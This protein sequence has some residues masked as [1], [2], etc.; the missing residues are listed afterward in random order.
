[1]GNRNSL[2]STTSLT[3]IVSDEELQ[4]W[5]FVRDV[6]NYAASLG[7]EAGAALD[8]LLTQAA[9]R[10]DMCT[11][12]NGIEQELDTT[13][14]E[15]PV[16]NDYDDDEAER[17]EAAFAERFRLWWR[18]TFAQP[19]ADTLRPYIR[20]EVRERWRAV[21]TILR[22]IAGDEAAA[23]GRPTLDEPRASTTQRHLAAHGRT[24]LTGRG[25]KPRPR[26]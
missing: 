14:L 17:V 4:N 26:R 19:C 24:P 22:A 7:W 10:I 6:R 9:R 8:N 15:A 5:R 20:A 23:W 16:E 3:Q 13:A 1:M 11:D 2:N 18:D 21:A 12:E 25:N